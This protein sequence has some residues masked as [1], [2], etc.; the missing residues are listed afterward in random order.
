LGKSQR[1]L[2]SH[3]WEELANCGRSDSCERFATTDATLLLAEVLRPTYRE[4]IPS[5][6]VVTG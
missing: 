1:R 2:P 4:M 5:C 3:P 6:E